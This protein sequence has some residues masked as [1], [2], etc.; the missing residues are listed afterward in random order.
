MTFVPIITDVIYLEIPL[1]LNM[2]DLEP[3]MF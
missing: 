1:N 3:H 2:A